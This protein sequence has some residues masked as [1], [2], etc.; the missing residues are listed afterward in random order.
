MSANGET[1]GNRKQPRDFGTQAAPPHQARLSHKEDTC[2]KNTN[3]EKPCRHKLQAKFIG[4]KDCEHQNQ[5]PISHLNSA[6][7][8]N[9]HSINSIRTY[10]VTEITEVDDKGHWGKSW[11]SRCCVSRKQSIQRQL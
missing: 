10:G 5:K 2:S 8:V 1:G 3:P 9:C 11:L 6:Q 7:Q 4:I